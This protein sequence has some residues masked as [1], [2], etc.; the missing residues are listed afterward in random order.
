[1]QVCRQF[2]EIECVSKVKH[3]YVE[4]VVEVLH[5]QIFDFAGAGH[6]VGSPYDLDG[7]P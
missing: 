2:T 3:V 7:G 6:T 4:I 5:H 1:M